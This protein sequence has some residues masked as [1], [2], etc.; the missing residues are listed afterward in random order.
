MI[1][2]QTIVDNAIKAN[3]EAYKTSYF[4]AQY[5]ENEK[6]DLNAEK[7]AYAMRHEYRAISDT[8]TRLFPDAEDYIRKALTDLRVE[9]NKEMDTNI[10]QVLLELRQDC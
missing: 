2:M 3:A 5:W 6:T 7:F 1:N 9:V 4:H 8:L 10:E